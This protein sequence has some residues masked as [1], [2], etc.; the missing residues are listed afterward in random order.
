MAEPTPWEIQRPSPNTIEALGVRHA[1]EFLLR[2]V[3][4]IF[5]G[6]AAGIG[7]GLVIQ[8]ITPTAFQS[9]GKFVVD[10]LPF[11]KQGDSAGTD[12]ETERQLVQTLI[13][14]IASRDMQAAVAERLGIEKERLAFDEIDPPLKLTKAAPQANIELTATKE[15]RIGVVN[16]TSQS[17]EFA[18]QV[19]NAIL[20]QLKLYNQIGGQ[21]K[22]L[23]LDL[24]L[25]RS[26]AD[27]IL[28]QYLAASEKRI[29]LEQQAAEFFEYKKRNLPVESFTAFST[30]P[31]LNNLK[32]Q[33]ILV[34]SEYDRI[35]A[36]VTAGGALAGKRSE[37]QGLERQITQHALALSGA[38][39][40]ELEIV[41]TRENDLQ[42]ELAKTQTQIQQM[43]DASARLTQSY[44]DPV[45][46]RKIIQDSPGSAQA[47]SNVV[48]IID[49]ASPT[50]KPIRPKLT[51][52]LAL[53]IL[54][55]GVLGFGAAAIRT[56]LD[57]RLRTPE[58]IEQ[59]TGQACLA[60]LPPLRSGRINRR[61]SARL[62]TPLGLS[63]LRSHFLRTAMDAEGRHVIGFTPSRKGGD[64]A[65]LVADLAVLLANAEQR[66]LVIDLD[67]KSPRI[68]AMLGV[69]KTDG[70]NEWLDSGEPLRACVGGTTIRELAVLGFG[71][72]TAELDDQLAGRPLAKELAALQ[73]DWDFI[74]IASPSI[75]FDWTLM[76]AL[77]SGSPVVIAADYRKST[78]PD[79]EATV[80]RARGSHW[81]V[82]GV[83]LQNCPRRAAAA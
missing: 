68:A 44:G 59:R 5:L 34:K 26:K 60:M 33:L 75:R 76:L 62:S 46:M 27:S 61:G 14:S 6:L 1:L 45:A 49:R 78:V 58:L 72:I 32:T 10:E 23:R 69:A 20:D 4:L 7:L 22:Q 35:A 3:L 43:N 11:S 56:L 50:K 52:N 15:S 29:T 79:L 12:A 21:L 54:V 83:V 13:L 36:T 8:K 42:R 53:G 37:V 74:L 82:E 67:R 2:N 25:A 64:V 57:N 24:N 66:T 19:V 41:R 48:V 65:R 81:S 70:L 31:T 28:A 38:L 73:E 51:L 71:R 55:G 39:V 9:K 17:S 16:A 30:D 63:F 18:A 80:Q 77:P 40:S 47:V